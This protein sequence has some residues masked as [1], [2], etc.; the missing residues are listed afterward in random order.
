MTAEN[1]LGEFLKDKRGR[2]D[3]ALFGFSVARRRTPG[4][5]REEVAQLAHISPA[6]YTWLEQGRG[7]APSK[8]VL[9]RLSTT[10]QLNAAEKEYLFLLA[11][12]H[13]P[14]SKMAVSH[15][16]SPRIQRVLDAFGHC[17][18]IIKTATWDV[19][20]WN[21][22]ARFVLND[23]EKLPSNLRNTLKLIFLDPKSKVIQQDWEVV[24]QFVVNSF[25][26][27]V[28]RIG[29]SDSVQAL[30]D[31]LSQQSEDFVRFWQ[32]NEVS[33]HA[34]GEK[35]LHHPILGAIDLEFS[36]FVVEGRPDL[37]M[38]VFNPS[39]QETKQKIESHLVSL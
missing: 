17:P 2:L 28:T 3:P 16:L 11:F 22:A 6:W 34:G 36:S 14:D 18:A 8:E 7:G 20:A 31:E 21:K 24:A 23:Y 26:A 29:I 13:P 39:S 32:S 5:R 38:L 35:R 25:R 10:L 15:E 4:L 1:R 33:D 37:N 12:G 9:N 27:D 19:I 30:I